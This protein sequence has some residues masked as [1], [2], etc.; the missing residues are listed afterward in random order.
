MRRVLLSPG[1]WLLVSLVAVGAVGACSDDEG[2]GGSSATTTSSTTGTTSPTTTSSTTAS[3]SSSS[4]GG[5]GTG[6]AGG[7]VDS[8]P[9][10]DE[11]PDLLSETGLYS[12]IATETIA[13]NV[14]EFQPLY[15]LWSDGAVK[16]RWVYLPEC[17][18]IDTSNM[19]VW[20]MP[21]GTRLWKQFVR[22]GV[23]V[24]TRLIIRT[25]PGQTDFRFAAYQWA[26]DGSDATRLSDGAENV[27]GTDHDIPSEALCSGCHRKDWR[28]LGFSALQLT[29][30]MP[31]LTIASLSNE[32]RLT[33]P[34][35]GGIVVPGTPVEQAALGY[36][37]AN[38]ASCHNRDASGVPSLYFKVLQEN[39]DVAS[40]D[41]YTTTI[42]QTATMFP[43]GCDRVEPG[44]PASSAVYQRMSVRGSG[45]QMPQLATEVVDPAGLQAVSDWISQLPP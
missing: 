17:Q 39:A 29:H 14:E 44:N 33:T 22:D 23:H 8:L 3:S 31:G 10:L 21:V 28:V 45:A 32:D 11:P 13:D 4:S 1:C 20:E 6:G 26:E 12:D 43:C 25:G 42:N 15:P 41:T 40:T 24:E 34:L 2:S 36:L 18:K 38:C 37:H 35:P 30:D 5:G 9:V 7:C 27:N 16:T 19:D